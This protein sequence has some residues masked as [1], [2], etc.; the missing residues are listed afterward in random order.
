MLF[1]ITKFPLLAEEKNNTDK[2]HPQYSL[3]FEE[4]L[5]NL[6]ITDK[7]KLVNNGSISITHKKGRKKTLAY[8]PS[9]PSLD[10]MHKIVSDIKPNIIYET[11]FL[12][13]TID[14]QEQNSIM[15]TMF[16]Y[17]RNIKKFPNIKYRNIKKGFIYPIFLS[18]QQIISLS[19]RII[20]DTLPLVTASTFENTLDTQQEPIFILQDMP[21]FGDVVSEYK[22]EYNNSFASFVGSNITPIFHGTISAVK[23]QEMLT[24]LWVFRTKKGILIYGMGLVRIRGIA[25]LFKGT[26]ENSFESRMVGLFNWI[27]NEYY[28]VK[29][30]E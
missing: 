2:N 11:I 15:A 12:I 23:E 16:N 25:V 5:N 4:L 10:S 30:L 28:G 17:I 24:T 18:S 20:T 1:F 26:I 3:S 29:Q 13:S 9:Y 6:S 27:H 14:L 19:D 7:D 8:I 22:Y 21:P